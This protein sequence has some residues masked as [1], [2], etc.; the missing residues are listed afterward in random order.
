M[1]TAHDVALFDGL[2]GMEYLA[3]LGQ[4]FVRG[5]SVLGP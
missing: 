3:S 4:L 5:W 1:P 2:P